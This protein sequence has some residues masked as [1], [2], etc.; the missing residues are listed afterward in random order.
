MPNSH[1][2]RTVIAPTNKSIQKSL[3]VKS[4]ISFFMLYLFGCIMYYKLVEQDTINKAN[5]TAMQT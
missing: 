5:I 3:F 1:R 4:G 2:I